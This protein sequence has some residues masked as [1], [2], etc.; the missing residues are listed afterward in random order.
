[1]LGASILPH[2]NILCALSSSQRCRL[3]C[4]YLRAAR[5]FEPTSHARHAIELRTAML[6]LAHTPSRR[7]SHAEDLD[8]PP[9][10]APELR[11]SHGYLSPSPPPSEDRT[12]LHTTPMRTVMPARALFFN[13]LPRP[14]PPHH[15]RS[16][17]SPAVCIKL[18]E[19]P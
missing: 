9:Q 5:H 13:T 14:H 15:S 11:S 3:D 7:L 16:M 18:P 1:M 17:Q 10:H 12:S 19:F 2:N 8:S 4:L 6:M